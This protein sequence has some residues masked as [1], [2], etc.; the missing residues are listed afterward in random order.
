MKELALFL[1]FKGLRMRIFDSYDSCCWSAD[2]RFNQDR[3]MGICVL[4][5]TL[6]NIGEVRRRGIFSLLTFFGREM[7][8]SNSTRVFFIPLSRRE[9]GGQ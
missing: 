9:E 8:L 6:R 1:D 2:A 3:E 7:A 4:C 5:S